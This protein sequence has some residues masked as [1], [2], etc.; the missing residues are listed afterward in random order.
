MFQMKKY[1]SNLFGG[2]WR[3]AER[4]SVAYLGAGTSKFENFLLIIL[5]VYTAFSLT[6]T[7]YIGDPIIYVDL[8]SDKPGWLGIWFCKFFYGQ[9]DAK[10]HGSLY[11]IATIVL[12]Y[13]I[14][15]VLIVKFV[16]RDKL[17]N[18]GVSLRNVK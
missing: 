1:L 2:T 15:P 4:S 11:W 6:V 18:Y 8:V 16:F 10:F 7:H 5:L 14:I 17:S 13:L 3:K 9:H 12:F